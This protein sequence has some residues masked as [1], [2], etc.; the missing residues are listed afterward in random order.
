MRA[1]WLLLLVSVCSP[2]LWA[3][4]AVLPPGGDWRGARLAVSGDRDATVRDAEGRRLFAVHA[5]GAEGAT[6][7]DLKLEATREALLVDARECWS[8]GKVSKLSFVGENVAVPPLAG[9]SAGRRG[10]RLVLT[11]EA[12]GSP[13]ARIGTYLEGVRGK[14]RRHWYQSRQFALRENGRV[15]VLRREVPDDVGSLHPRFDIQAPGAGVLAIKKLQIGCDREVRRPTREGEGESARMLFHAPFDGSLK[16][17]TAAG[18]GDSATAAAF[19]E[20]IKGSCI[21]LQRMAPAEYALAG[22]LDLRRGAISFWAK[23][24]GDGIYNSRIFAVENLTGD[25]AASGAIDIHFDD[26]ALV[27]SQQNDR[28]A[29]TRVL[30]VPDGEWNHYAVNWDRD[31]VEVYVNGELAP[32]QRRDGYSPTKPVWI[33]DAYEYEPLKFARFAIGGGKTA[34][35]AFA[36]KFPGCIDEFKVYSAPLSSQAVKEIVA[37]DAPGWRKPP[38]EKIDWAKAFAGCGDNPYEGAVEPIP[39][40]GDWKAHGKLFKEIRLER[41]DEFDDSRLRTTAPITV[42]E[43]N[44]VKYFEAGSKQHDRF[45]LNIPTPGGKVCYVEF[46]Y[47]DDAMRSMD[48]TCTV[49]GPNWRG[50]P[51]CVGVL[52]GRE[53]K[54][55]HRMQTHRCLVWNERAERIVAYVMTT[56]DNE[57]AALAAVRVYEIPDGKLPQLAINAPEAVDGERRTFG[58]Y[59]EDPAIGWSIPTRY[60]TVEG[61]G[62]AADRYMALMKFNGYNALFYPGAWYHGLIGAD[63]QPRPHIDGFYSAWYTKF[64]REGLAFVPTIGIHNIPVKPG[65]ITEQSFESGELHRTAVNILSSGKPNPGGWHPTPPNFNIAHPET[66]R[67][68]MKAFDTLLAEGKDHPS[69]KGVALHLT[70]HMIGWWGTIEGGYNDYVIEAF[71]KETGVKVPVDRSDPARGRLYAEWLLK[72]QYEAWVSWRCRVITRFY[73]ELAA[74]LREARGDLKLWLYSYV[75]AGIADDNGRPHW[76]DDDYVERRNREGGLDRAALVRA[77]PNLVLNQVVVPAEGRWCTWIRSYLPDVSRR[78]CSLPTEARTFDLLAGAAFPGLGIH[79]KYFESDIGHRTRGTA[80]GLSCAW[81]E[82]P[83]W[84]CT[85]LNPSRFYA[86]KHYVVPLRH[87]D[88]LSMVKGGYGIG[89]Y[90]TENALAPFVQAYRALPAVVMNDVKGVGDEIVKMREARVN[91]R[92]YAYVVN[93]GEETRRFASDRLKGL[94]N[95][96]TGEQLAGETLELAPYSLVA[97]GGAADAADAGED[98]AI[99]LRPNADDATA[100]FL[101]ALDALRT[102]GGGVIELAPGDYHFRAASATPMQ[103]YISNH[104]QSDYHPVQ[105]PLTGLRNVRIKGNGAR[106]IMHGA[107]I[108]VAIVDSVGVTLEGV[109]IDWARPFVTSAWIVDVKDGETTVEIDGEKEPYAVEDGKFYAIGEGW[110]TPY[111]CMLVCRGD[112]HA[113][114]EGTTD[115][116]WRGKFKPTAVKD[117]WILPLDLKAKNVRPGDCLLI[118]PDKR[119]FPATVVYRAHDTRFHDVALQTAWGMGVI[120][121][122]S[123]NF[124]WTGS[125]PAAARR[126]GVFAPTGE[127]R[128]A[129]LN[130]DATHF[131]NVKGKVEIENCLFECMMDDA[132]NVH[133]TCL[134]VT[135]KIDERTLRCRYMHRQAYG[136]EVF[137]AGERLRFIR[138]KTLENGPVV[139]VKEVES[140]DPYEVVVTLDRAIPAGYGAGDAVENADYQPSVVFRGNIVARNRARGTLFTTPKPVLV[141]SNLFERVSGSAILFAG[142]SQ[143]W[144]ESGACENVVVRGNTFRDCLTSAYDYCEGL[145]SFYPM[146]RDVA[147]QK[148]RYHRNITI[149]DNLI[150]TFDVPLIFA[151]STEDVTFRRNTVRLNNRFP[152]RGKGRFVLDHCG[153]FETSA[154]NRYLAEPAP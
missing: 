136:F 138:G 132:I 147:K 33:D 29:N 117:R 137:A 53:Y 31:A 50:S 154:G 83:G 85:V 5:E 74:R 125:G 149:E 63:Y 143:G 128:F 37:A 118:R 124:A 13:G 109:S 66:R 54:N 42:K 90:G 64:D 99:R 110:K 55:S 67:E 68:L 62:D 108:G 152:G 120:C 3:A 6:L 105:L 16:A 92:Y 103:F 48:I 133:S 114:V 41:L 78:Q 88:I 96:V 10:A 20:G 130:A 97:L 71:E 75:T 126:S 59:Y 86:R 69:F 102:R 11:F 104:D 144:Y 100:D 84:R 76:Q 129:T 52:T 4:S 91:G 60:Y 15:S 72:N 150:E 140:I 24:T 79:D 18:D 101:A 95:L 32:V 43:L 30:V 49:L 148:T 127:R 34:G 116:W 73:A 121:Q 123:E 35:G 9:G 21:D 115:I 40:D 122:R 12:V 23:Q 45:A 19:A 153:A 25:D 47:P 111:E 89:F 14:E 94:T 8:R 98:A 44:G 17:A 139:T 28:A 112:S 107:T 22:N 81:S 58:V 77:I 142:D 65:L 135:E 27:F 151:I 70:D 1:C 80:Q 87:R 141:E 39:A 61:A 93:T 56:R 131:S 134:G 26:R 7:K 38:R 113:I 82:E 36:H 119:P 57:S 145:F 46:D 2:S 106:F 146:I 51:M